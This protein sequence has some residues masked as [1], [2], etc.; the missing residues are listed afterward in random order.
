M[1][2]NNHKL[3][4]MP[5]NATKIKN[6]IERHNSKSKV[7]NKVKEREKYELYNKLDE[8]ILDLS[9]EIYDSLQPKPEPHIIEIN[10][11][12]EEEMLNYIKQHAH[13]GVG[14]IVLKFGNT[15]TTY[16][17]SDQSV[18]TQILEEIV[19]QPNNTEI[20]PIPALN[21]ET[22]NNNELTLKPNKKTEK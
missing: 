22:K 11:A 6:Y 15:V 1:R 21:K 19:V 12:L 13:V 14:I 20:K 2:N 3:K 16:N 4:V 17:L 5:S 9:Q 18:T 10:P 8:A 7:V